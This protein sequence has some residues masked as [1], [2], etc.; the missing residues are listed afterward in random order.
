MAA[1]P[2]V[3]KFEPATVDAKK[4]TGQVVIRSRLRRPRTGPDR[5][6]GHLARTFGTVEAAFFDLD[7]TV[8]AKASI[9]AFARDFRRE[10][11]LSRRTVA[12]RLWTQLVYVHV[13]AG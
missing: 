8:I 5:G 6:R 13:G 2:G 7:K 10:G 9:M 3:L 4:P 12:K 11:L 1:P